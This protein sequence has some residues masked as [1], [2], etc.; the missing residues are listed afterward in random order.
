MAI[1]STVELFE[2]SGSY[3]ENWKRE[4]VRTWR[5]LSSTRSESAMAVMLGGPVRHGEIY[6]VNGDE[7]AGAFVRRI[8]V[9]RDASAEDGL[10]WIFTATYGP[11]DPNLNPRLPTARPLQ[12]SWIYNQV[13]MVVDADKEGDAIVNSAGDPYEPALTEEDARPIL[14]IVRYQATFNASLADEYRNAIN[15]DVWMGADPLTVRALPITADLEW[16]ADEGWVW[17]VTYQFAYKRDGWPRVVLD[18][19]KRAKTTISGTT[20]LTP[21][22]KGGVPVEDA[23]PLNGSGAALAVGGTPVFNTHHTRPEL[24]FNVFGFAESDFPGIVWS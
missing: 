23:V 8:G 12:V 5:I 6:D 14:Q 7:D 3:D 10:S 11:Y 4:F 1:V 19:G 20:Y 9:V 18:A 17:K 22:L 16:D 13:D 2:T 24:P 21:I 15:S